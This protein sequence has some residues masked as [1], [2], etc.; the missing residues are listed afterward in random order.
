MFRNVVAALNEA[1]DIT[2]FLKPMTNHFQVMKLYMLMRNDFNRKIT[3]VHRIFKIHLYFKEFGNKRFPGHHSSATASDALH[4]SG[5][6]PINLLQLSGSNHC[7]H[8]G[9]L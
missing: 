8:A 4:L 2:L 9:N 6:F 1:Q 7:H 3:I 5:V